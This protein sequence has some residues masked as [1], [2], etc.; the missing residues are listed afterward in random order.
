MYCELQVT[1]LDTRA[2]I[3]NLQV[4]SSNPQ[5]ASSSRCKL[6]VQN[7]ELQVQNELGD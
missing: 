6:W 7:H 5:V 4:T 3:S 2:T 1:S